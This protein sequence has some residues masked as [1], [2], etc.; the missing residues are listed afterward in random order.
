MTEVDPKKFKCDICGA[1]ATKWYGDTSATVC[2]NQVCYDTH[3]RRWKE[4]YEE[5]K[6]QDDEDAAWR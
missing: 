3:D 4:A 6:N 2:D 5:I 1:P